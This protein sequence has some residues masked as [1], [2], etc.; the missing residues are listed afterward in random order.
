MNGIVLLSSRVPA[1]IICFAITVVF[2]SH[3]ANVGCLSALQTETEAENVID[4]NRDIKPLLSDRCY[5]CHGPDGG[6]RKAGFRLDDPASA[7][8]EA[9]S[10]LEP[11]VPGDPD[12]SELLRRILLPAN[13]IDHMPPRNAHK[14]SLTPEEIEKIRTWIESGAKFDK[15]W[16]FV[17]PTRP[18]VPAD[19]THWSANSIDQ[20]LVR[21]MK[22][23]GLSPSKQAKKAKLLRRITFDLTGLPPTVEELDDFLADRDE[24]AYEKIVDRLLNSPRYGEH[25][26]RY[27]LDAVRYGDT[28]GLH[29]DNYREIWPYR[30]WVIQAFN[31][32]MSWDNFTTKQ[33]AGDL[34]DQPT[35]SDLVASGYNRMHVST[36]EGGSIK[37][38]VYVRNVVDRVSTTGSVFLGLSVGCA[39]CH[40][41][42]FDPISAND[43][44][45]MFAFFNNLDADPMDGNKKDHAPVLPISSDEYSQRLA[46]IDQ[47]RAEL[48]AQFD[49][50]SPEFDAAFSS[51]KTEWRKRLNSRW[52]DVELSQAK[53]VQGA[54][55]D[56]SSDLRTVTASGDNPAKD[57]FELTFK[58][59]ETDITGL[60][61]SA[62]LGENGLAG[63][64]PNGNVVLSEVKVEVKPDN[65]QSKFEPI[66]FASA[67]ADYSQPNFLIENAID[68]I[69][70]NQNGWGVNGH[71]RQEDLT[72]AFFAD[73][74]F[75]FD[76]G[77]IV[78][79]RLVFETIHVQHVFQKIQLATTTD[80]NVGIHREGEWHRIGPFISKNRREAFDKDFGPETE[81]DLTR[82]Y[83]FTNADGKENELRWKTE[84]Y[85]DGSPHVFAETSIGPTYLFREIISPGA[86]EIS[87]SLGS[88]DGIK[89][90]LNGDQILANDVAR[91]V[92]A[93]QES[94]TLKLKPGLNRLLL[95]VVNIG[96]ACGFYYAEKESTSLEPSLTIQSLLVSDKPTTEE[97]ERELKSFYGQSSPILRKLNEQIKAVDEERAAAVAARPTTLIM[98]ERMQPKP[99][100]LLKRGEYDQPDKE[101]GPIPRGVPSFLPPLPEGAPV[102]RMGFAQWLLADEHP[103]MARVTVN[104]FWHQL[105]GAG[106]VTTPDDFGSQGATPTHPQ[107]LDWLAVE[108]REGGWN[109][110][111]L[112]KIIVMSKT[113]QQDSAMTT[114][115]LQADPKNQWLARGPRYRLDAEVL[116]DQALSVSGLIHHQLGGPGVKP[117]Q[118]GGLWK[119]VGYSS[120]NTANFRADKE[121]QKVHRRS[122]YTFWKRTSPPP[123]MTVFDAPSREECVIVR[124]RT[125]NP[126][127]ALLLLN[128]PQYFE[129][130]RHLAERVS[131]E[132]KEAS[133]DTRAAWMFFLAT[134]RQPQ[135][136]ETAI[137]VDIFNQELK[138]YQ[139]DIESAKKLLTVGAYP[140]PENIDL[141]EL[142][143]WTVVANTV[144]NLDEIVNKQ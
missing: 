19:P 31:D 105:M 92:A 2:V 73:T 20:F 77:T 64:A 108:F 82:A 140:P 48:K 100:Y 116:R 32:N 119:A 37:E 107:L 142:A 8:A 76:E 101:R 7:L 110:K 124:E 57:T 38:E 23:N 9:D 28:H 97:Q 40:D 114:E 21:R 13:D 6:S 56:I 45:S 128:D 54:T 86:R 81:I 17:A 137:L 94:L 22:E 106:I 141:S 130:A 72:A 121:P 35:D 127:Q 46:S 96:G 75:G 34:L 24:N 138:V 66:R 41:H 42:K 91:G 78:R 102:D 25:M 85:A 36:N 60:R 93:D 39:Q 129:A 111:Q 27:W 3:F 62:I 12:E 71:K 83:A 84:N 11:I 112:V 58:T 47:R 14:P 118:P 63:R 30:D 68:G 143:A 18:A 131:R 113:Y 126:L 89:V 79:V 104:R 135:A 103:L 80:K 69:I 43:F 29:L 1:R 70:D 122:I 53:S 87:V 16:A 10:G 33:I 44:Y 4:F 136:Q 50:P 49:A 109:V 139:A 134:S 99:A 98:K 132:K 144:L 52:K 55:L 5:Q 15:H 125:N 90:W 74:P 67:D 120:S 61:L 133:V 51:W 123:Q 65:D 59:K 115:Q 88:D 117:P 26:A 95:K